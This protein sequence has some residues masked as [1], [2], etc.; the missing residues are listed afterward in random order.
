MSCVIYAEESNT[1]L[2]FEIGVSENANVRPLCN[3][4]PIQLYHNSFW[5]MKSSA[6][7][8]CLLKI[9]NQQTKLQVVLIASIMPYTEYSTEPIIYHHEVAQF[10]RNISR[11]INV[12]QC[13]QRSLHW[14]SNYACSFCSC[15]LLARRWLPN[16]TQTSSTVCQW[17]LSSLDKYA[18][19][20]SH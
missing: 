10:H 19:R 2:S 8:F 7:S 9:E 11:Q 20:N 6:T 13:W 16:E 5:D 18:W 1:G 17:V 14:W 3:H 4:W 12:H 15:P